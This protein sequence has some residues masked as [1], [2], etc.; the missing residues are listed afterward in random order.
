MPE[1]TRIRA[2]LVESRV[3]RDYG[4]NWRLESTGTIVTCLSDGTEISNV[5]PFLGHRASAAKHAV[6]ESDLED[7]TTEAT[8]H[9]GSPYGPNYSHGYVRPYHVDAQRA[10]GM[11][12]A[13]R[14]V[15]R[16]L[17]REEDRDGPAGSIGHHMARVAR[18]VGATAIL[19]PS[20][21]NTGSTYAANA[22]HVH[23]PGVA[24]DRINLGIRRRQAS[25]EG[26]TW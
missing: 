18:A 14:H 1:S 13:L 9:A 20:D 15:D 21:Q 22:Y 10:A 17:A 16:S 2:L 25:A 11:L 4:D 7:F 5:S 3:M 24:V 8:I 23:T 6:R 19:L 12:R 26:V